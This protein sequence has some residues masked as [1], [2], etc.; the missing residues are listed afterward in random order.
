MVAD[1]LAPCGLCPVDAYT[2]H[3]FF[4]LIWYRVLFGSE[5]VLPLTVKNLL[6]APGGPA[7]KVPLSLDER[8]R[9]SLIATTNAKLMEGA[10]PGTAA[11]WVRVREGW[12]LHRIAVCAAAP[13]AAEASA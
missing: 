4:I 2:T 3:C 1:V 11:R 10:T 12:H 7:C 9:G 8:A 13:A 5:R 6:I